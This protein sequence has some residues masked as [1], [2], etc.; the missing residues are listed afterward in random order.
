MEVQS[1]E[2]LSKVNDDQ[3]QSEV[4]ISK[5]QNRSPKPKHGL[6][7]ATVNPKISIVNPTPPNIQLIDPGGTVGTDQKYDIVS[8]SNKNG[9][10]V[11]MKQS[12]IPAPQ[13]NKE[14][15]FTGKSGI[16]VQEKS[17]LAM[18]GFVMKEKP[19]KI[20]IPEA[21]INQMANQEQNKGETGNQK[22]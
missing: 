7:E 4:P 9:S 19:S 5:E 20:L 3:V 2:N 8:I 13:Q 11:G 18:N 15:G 10:D 12:L 14:L 1:G 21:H 17:P 16:T 6:Q 22:I